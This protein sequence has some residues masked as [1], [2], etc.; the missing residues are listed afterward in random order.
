MWGSTASTWTRAIRGPALGARM[1]APA[2]C[3]LLPRLAPPSG[4]PAPS[5][6]QPP[7]ARSRWLTRATR[8]PAWTVARV[9]WGAWTATLAP[10]PRASRVSTASCRITAPRCRVVMA[11]SVNPLVTRTSVR[12]PRGSWARP[13]QRTSWSARMIR[14]G[15]ATAS[16]H[17]DHTSKRPLLDQFRGRGFK[18]QSNVEDGR[19]HRGC[20]PVYI[21]RR[22]VFWWWRLAVS[23]SEPSG[24]IF[25]TTRCYIPEDR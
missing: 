13:A 4:A 22:F 14:A 9:R 20:S 3:G 5:A 19:L 15:T 25:Q 21:H 16:T 23:P 18:I 7:C 17:T 11:P 10:A 1:G 6:T 2:T 8:T 12:V 24:T